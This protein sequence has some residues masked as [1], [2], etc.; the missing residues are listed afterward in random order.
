MNTAC[1]GNRGELFSCI[2]YLLI[3]MDV[4]NL[5][6]TSFNVNHKRHTHT[7]INAH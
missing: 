3:Y 1:S 7:N 2:R 6:L 5:Y 4:L